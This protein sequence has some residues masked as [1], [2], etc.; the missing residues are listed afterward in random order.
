MADPNALPVGMQGLAAR[1][2]D[3]GKTLSQ[4]IGK[5]LRRLR[6][7]EAYRRT[8]M[9]KDDQARAIDARD[10]LAD[11]GRFCGFGTVPA[12]HVSADQVRFQQG[13]QAMYL[14]VIERCQMDDQELTAIA[15]RIKEGMKHD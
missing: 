4:K 10:V 8:F 1:I 15:A 5:H 2:E 14:H 12:P 13:M 9:P 3:E 11:L 7:K 6:V